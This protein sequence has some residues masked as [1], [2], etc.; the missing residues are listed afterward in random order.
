M[1]DISMCTNR[2]CPSHK[3]CYRFRAIPDEWQ[4]FMSSVPDPRT[5]KCGYFWPIDGWEVAEYDE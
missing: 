2:E 5:G 3:D 1:P 4:S